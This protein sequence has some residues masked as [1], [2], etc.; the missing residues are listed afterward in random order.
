MEYRLSSSTIKQYKMCPFKFYCKISKQEK[1]PDSDNT[2]GNA[3]NAVHKALEYYYGQQRDIPLKL[4]FIELKK[5]FTNI[6]NEFEINEKLV[7]FDLYWL[8]VVNGVKLD[9]NP[10]HLEYEFGFKD[11]VE[12]IGYAD[13]INTKEHWIGDW[14]TSTYKAKKLEDYKEQLRFY[15]YAYRKEFGANP[16]CW[17]FFNK[18]N[19]IFKFKFPDETLDSIDDYFANLEK[20]IANRI[21]NLDFP[22][23]PSRG[24]CYF[25]Y[26]K[27]M[28]ATDLLRETKSKKYEVLFHI[29]KDKLMIEG[30]IPDIIHRRMESH[31]NYKIKNAQFIIKAMAAKGVKYDGIKRLYKRKPYGA[32][33]SPGYMHFIWKELKDYCVSKGMK[34]SLTLKDW[35]SQLNSD[36]VF[37][38]KLN[39]EFTPYQWQLDSVDALI[40]HR[41]GVCEVGTGGGKT[42]IA[43]ECI[44]RL[45]TRTLFVI[46]KKDLLRQTKEEYEK[47]LDME[48]GIVGM[49]E[50]DWSKPVTL[51]TI[52]TLTKHLAEWATYLAEINLVIFDETHI[53]AAKSFEK[54]SKYL[55]NSKYRLGFSATA[56]RDD[57][58]DNLIFAHTG[59]VV[60]RKRALALI[61][62]GVLVNP[63]VDFYSYECKN[64]V[65]ENWQNEY[66]SGIVLNDNRNALIK[67]IAEDFANKDKQVMILVK[68]IKNGHAHW[69][70]DNIEN[71]N[72]IYGK[73]EDDIRVDLLEKFK[74]KEFKILIGSIAIFNKGINIKALDVLINI[75]GNAGD[76]ATVQSIGRA[77]R[78]NEGKD[79][80]YYVDFIDK[81]EY[82][83]KHSISRVNALKQEGYE[84]KIHTY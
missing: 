14:K 58:N 82:L 54:L 40:K 53:I 80:A 50:A 27:N 32:L 43:A 67:K 63:D 73:T 79:K 76:V 34:L 21:E 75:S 5:V 29:K 36:V 45:H 51:A 77:L 69:L 59:E 68:D 13:V 42:F 17:V 52:Q 71:A 38:P 3:G 70:K 72:L 7:D 57:G 19:K 55:I 56:K 64:P 46:D 4:A 18:V 84:P 25:C 74:K 26:Y 39:T 12:F 16:M 62:E 61:E 6:W 8:C 48:C 31:I 9:L 10:T 20:S 37:D 60:Y 49:G 78:K 66:V 33:T 81:G 83:Y 23:T 35:R 44:R 28:C 2:Y 1:D 41:W 47:M 11:P 30:E 22:R 65:A 15:A 24:A